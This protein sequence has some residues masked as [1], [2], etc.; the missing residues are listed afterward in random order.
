MWQHASIFTGEKQN[1]KQS[2]YHLLY[3]GSHLCRSIDS[4]WC[5]GFSN[6]AIYKITKENSWTISDFKVFFPM[7]QKRRTGE[8]IVSLGDDCDHAQQLWTFGTY[9]S[10]HEAYVV[11]ASNYWWLRCPEKVLNAF[12]SETVRVWSFSMNGKKKKNGSKKHWQFSKSSYWQTG[13]WWHLR[14][15]KKLRLACR[16]HKDA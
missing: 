14:L 8:I 1:K 2:K 16:K 15:L 12:L 4:G 6:T 7:P 5:M 11:K 9:S 13:N 10:D 3:N